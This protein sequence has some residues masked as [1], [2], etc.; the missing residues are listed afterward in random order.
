MVSR[1]KVISSPH[2]PPISPLT[3]LPPMFRLA[4]QS[5]AIPSKIEAGGLTIETIPFWVDDVLGNVNTLIGQ[6]A[7]EKKLELVFSVNALFQLSLGIVSLSS[8][9][10]MLVPE[11]GDDLVRIGY[12]AVRCRTHSRTSSRTELTGGSYLDRRGHH[13]CAAPVLLAMLVTHHPLRTWP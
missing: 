6:K 13:S 5:S 11:I 2:R 10:S 7:S 1:R 3:T 9:Q 12:R 4:A 8:A